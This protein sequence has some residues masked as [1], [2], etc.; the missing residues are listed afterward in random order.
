MFAADD[1]LGWGSQCYN[2]GAGIASGMSPKEI[3]KGIVAN[4]NRYY[5]EKFIKNRDE[6]ISDS[7]ERQKVNRRIKDSSGKGEVEW[8]NGKGA[9]S[10]G[11]PAD[12]VK[13]LEKEFYNALVEEAKEYFSDDED[14]QDEEDDDLAMQ[15]SEINDECADYIIVSEK[16]L[17]TNELSEIQGIYSYGA[18]V[19]FK[20][21]GKTQYAL[22]LE[23]NCLRIL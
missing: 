14:M 21:D 8:D 6:E 18:D 17:S 22:C 23:C 20:K 7:I 19:K 10:L 9:K 1:F 15:Y 5:F 12:F 16:E 2:I 11:I 13:K 4:E 3:K